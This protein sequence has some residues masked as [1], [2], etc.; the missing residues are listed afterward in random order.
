MF[1]RVDN[2]KDYWQLSDYDTDISTSSYSAALPFQHV[3]AADLFGRRSYF[4]EL[5]IRSSLWHNI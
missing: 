2:N 3:R 1:Y 5:F 4:V